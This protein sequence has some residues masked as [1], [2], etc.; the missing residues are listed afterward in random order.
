MNRARAISLAGLV[1]WGIGMFVDAEHAML[2]YLVAYGAVL[3]TVLGALFF[4]L[5]HHAVDAGW[6]TGVRRWAEQMLTALPLLALLA[7]PLVV[8]APKVYHWAAHDNSKAEWLNLPFFTARLALY[9]TLWILIA[10]YFRNGS[11]RQD[12]NG[13]P[14]IS[15][16]MRKWSAP[17][18]VV[19]GLSVNFAAMDLLMTPDYHWFSTIFGVY[20]WSQ[21]TL[22]FFAVMALL[23]FTKSL[24]PPVTGAVR[25]SIGLWLFAFTCF[26]GY[27]ALSQWLLIWYANIP[28]ETYWLLIRWEGAWRWLAVLA[29][30]GLFL[31]P[32]LAL[33]PEESKTKPVLR[34][35][36]WI[37]LVGHVLNLMWIVLPTGGHPAAFEA[38]DFD[39]GLLWI[40]VGA[41]ALLGGA[42]AYMAQHALLSASLYPT[43]DPRLA[44]AMPATDLPATEG[45]H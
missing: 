41:V 24:A 43:R 44:E 8:G 36:A 22:A 38:G 5:V 40:D 45:E 39:A 35:V 4:V 30:S 37:I 28:E 17:A 10:R 16:R 6:S 3:F 2:A 14:A 23:T 29:V 42:A 7:L 15:M 13:D 27:Q 31:I 18:L 21:G 26:W 9:F 1:V 34:R 11:L 19:Y 32:F 20:I 12:A 25:R 33:M